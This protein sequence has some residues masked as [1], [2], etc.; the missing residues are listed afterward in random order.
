[1]NGRKHLYN[2]TIAAPVVSLLCKCV[3][4]N[5]MFAPM[6]SGSSLI[7]CLVGGV[8]RL[9]SIHYRTPLYVSI[10]GL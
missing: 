2:E 9:P 10:Q 5:K 6:F 3:G 1:M 8:G 7:G 4:A